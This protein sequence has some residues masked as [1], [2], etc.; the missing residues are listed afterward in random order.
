MVLLFEYWKEWINYT[1]YFTIVSTLEK[2]PLQ[3][4]GDVSHV[5]VPDPPIENGVNYDD[6]N[7]D[8]LM[9]SHA[10]VKIQR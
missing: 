7:A 5:V 1:V 6:A 4:N 2:Q 10:S 8:E 3:Q 9:L